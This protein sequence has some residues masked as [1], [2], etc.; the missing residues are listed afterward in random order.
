MS[1][2]TRIYVSKDESLYLVSEP[3]TLPVTAYWRGVTWGADKFVAVADKSPATA[4][5]SSDG[6]LWNQSELPENAAYWDVAYG[7]GRFVATAWQV[8]LSY[9]EDGINWQYVESDCGAYNWSPITFGNGRFVAVARSNAKAIYSTDGINWTITDTPMAA[10]WFSMVY[11][12]GKF[13]AVGMGSSKALSS[14]DGIT[15]TAATIIPS[16]TSYSDT[17]YRTIA[18]GNGKFVVLHCSKAL[19]AYSEDGITWTEMTIP[20]G[21]WRALD[22][23]NGVFTALSSDNA[24]TM[25]SFDGINWEYGSMPIESSWIAITHNDKQFVAVA[26]NSKHFAYSYDG[27]TWKHTHDFIRQNDEDITNDIKDTL[28]LKQLAATIPTALPN[29]NALTIN[30]ISYDGSAPIDITEAVKSLLETELGVIENG[31]Y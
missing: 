20:E 14:P 3:Q 25:Y 10:D 22:F 23:N 8:P 6:I 27:I 16:L 11:G 30:G 18:F 13:V 21:T 28:G 29:P 7:H 31:T 5:Y 12:N 26:Y 15:W 4:A 19:G 24:K 1:T 2:N 9:S 17:D